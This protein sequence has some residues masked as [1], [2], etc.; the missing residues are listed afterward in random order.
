MTSNLDSEG[1]PFTAVLHQMHSDGLIH[2]YVDDHGHVRWTIT[3]LGRTFQTLIAEHADET[4]IA[5]RFEVGDGAE[6]H[7]VVTPDQSGKL[8]VDV[9]P[10]VR[11][12]FKD[13]D[14]P[15]HIELG[16]LN[17]VHGEPTI[18][19][20]VTPANPQRFG[21]D[22]GMARTRPRSKITKAE[23]ERVGRPVEFAGIFDRQGRLCAYSP[24]VQWGEGSSRTAKWTVLPAAAD[25]NED[26]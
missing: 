8:V 11:S 24:L 1:R 21:M 10:A 17:L 2:T 12:R 13:K 14:V 19:E 9:G 4:P 22:I 23:F 20:E 25:E 3:E 7:E 5:S 18:L 16:L 6:V 15:E 26:Q